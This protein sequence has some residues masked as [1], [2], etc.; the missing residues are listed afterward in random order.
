MTDIEKA[1]QLFC[2][3]GLAFP[4]F[5]MLEAAIA[6]SEDKARFDSGELRREWAKRYPRIFDE[7]EV[8]IAEH[9]EG[10]HFYE[11]FGAV[12]I[13]EQTGW[14]SLVE[15]YQF[16][17]QAWKREILR[18]LGAHN[19]ISFFDGLGR[20]GFGRMQAPDLLVYAP[21]YSE[22]YFCEVKGPTDNLRDRQKAYFAAMAAA[23]GDKEVVVLPIRLA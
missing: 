21:D 17:C 20:A 6:K 13:Y 19:L 22:Y 3:A 2:G 12:H 18:K 16:K 10:G 8:A 11:W 23:S 14:L 4:T 9:Q 7:R 1:R 15:S 5:R